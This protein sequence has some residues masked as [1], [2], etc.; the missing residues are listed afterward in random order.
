M[1]K[2]KDI[3]PNIIDRTNKTIVALKILVNCGA[4]VNEHCF[5]RNGKLC[6]LHGERGAQEWT[7]LVYAAYWGNI[8]IV[9]YLVSCG[10]NVNPHPNDRWRPLMWTPL[11]YAAKHGDH[12]MVRYLVDNGANVNT[13]SLRDQV[14]YR[15]SPWMHAIKLG[16]IDIL[17]F[18]VDNGA[19]VNEYSCT[20]FAV[21]ESN[22]N[23][24]MIQYLV[25]IDVTFN[26]GVVLEHAARYGH[27]E[28]I[29]Y[30]VNTNNEILNHPVEIPDYDD[31]DSEYR[32]FRL[33]YRENDHAHTY[34]EYALLAAAKNGQHHV[35]EYFI[36]Q[37]V[38]INARDCYGRTS[39]SLAVGLN[40]RSVVEYLLN[41][42][43]L[44]VKDTSGKTPLVYAIMLQDLGLVK[45]L[46]G[47]GAEMHDIT[48]QG[49]TIYVL[50]RDNSLPIFEYL[51]QEGMT[52]EGYFSK[53]P[54]YHWG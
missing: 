49:F 42:R 50:A 12:D 1:V 14:L 47:K 31:S 36:G 13:C 5:L 44:Q 22:D 21:S 32:N 40:R 15:L 18:L 17:K 53:K 20:T 37:K 35:V 23:L 43:A 26:I 34:G 51:K 2:E 11:M 39:L 24:E 48:D 54:S 33:Y 9:R 16:S 38:N 6:Q 25:S 46:I 52:K 28:L 45:L 8:D 29:K 27:L 3:N 30:L 7:P 10:A 4:D 41:N 19:N